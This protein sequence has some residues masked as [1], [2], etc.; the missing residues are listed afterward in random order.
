M[1]N[2][3]TKKLRIGGMTC[4]HCQNII[5]D[6]LKEATGVM[7]VK[8][9]YAKGTCEVAYDTQL[10]DIDKIQSVIED[11]EGF[12][13]KVLSQDTD[14][15]QISH[16]PATSAKRVIGLLLVIVATF[17]VLEYFNL[18][19][20]LTM[21]KAATSDMGF[22]MMFVIGLMTSVHCVG[23]CGGIV[24]S[25]CIGKKSAIRPA[26]LYNIGRLTSYTGVGFLVGLLGSAITLTT[27]MQGIVR[28]IAG[29]FMVIM[30]FN[31]LGLFPW[32]RRLNLSMPRFATKKINKKT[33]G[34]KSPLIIGF[35]TGFM[36]CGPLQAAQ[37]Y[38]LSTGN[39]FEGAL[40][41]FLFCAGT[42]PLLFGLGAFAGFLGSRKS[43]TNKVVTIGA[44]LV[45]VLGLSMFSQGWNLAGFTARHSEVE[46]SE[47]VTVFTV[48]GMTCNACVQAITKA[49]KTV[50]G[51]VKV[52]VTLSTGRVVIE[53]AAGLDAVLLRQ[54]ILETGYRI[55][56]DS[57]E[58]TVTPTEFATTEVIITEPIGTTAITAEVNTTEPIDTTA[59]TTEPIAMSNQITTLTISGMTCQRCVKAVTEALDA[60][61]G[62]IEMS[63]EIG[64]AVVEHD[65][66]LDESTI[67]TAII[68]AGFGVE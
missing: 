56:V 52:D 61:D 30:G 40:S 33:A 10:I 54:A 37:L 64:I 13:Y 19:G 14:S 65:E 8:V 28:L 41:M 67:K 32:L 60:L 59:I 29:V 53:H 57:D 47:T 35:L 6:E 22:I 58:V 31:M 49:V 46:T 34:N 12:D 5:E 7:D 18:L 63:V 4:I 24:L 17:V 50:D 23:M 66:S 39:P 68:N 20:F 45:A 2:I 9:S 15:G 48:E 43:L 27:S 51:V 16:N 38:A 1:N 44:V 42:I 62:V 11:I 3:E 21:G 26:F 55:A 25:Q 36:P